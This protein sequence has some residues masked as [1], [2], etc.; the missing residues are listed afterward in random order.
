M[1]IVMQMIKSYTKFIK[2]YN[3][4]YVPTELYTKLKLCFSLVKLLIACQSEETI[5]LLIDNMYYNELN[6]LL[7]LDD[8]VETC[9]KMNKSTS[10]DIIN[11]LL[12]GPFKNKLRIVSQTYIKST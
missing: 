11:S 4:Q 10:L 3:T 6:N 2:S 8:S 1:T 9:I 12:K 5:K 7:M